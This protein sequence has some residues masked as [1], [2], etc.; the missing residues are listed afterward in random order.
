[1]GAPFNVL[2]PGAT[3]LVAP[4]HD[5]ISHDMLLTGHYRR[6]CSQRNF[7]T[8]LITTRHGDVKIKPKLCVNPD[9]LFACL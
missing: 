5:I 9:L 1:M 7:F 4:L 6:K 3:D 2:P 8:W